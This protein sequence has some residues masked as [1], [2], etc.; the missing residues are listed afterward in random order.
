MISFLFYS[1]RYNTVPCNYIFISLVEI[2]LYIFSFNINVQ[3]FL[4]YLKE[5]GANV[6]I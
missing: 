6:T 1:I 4:G 5:D 2:I 3:D